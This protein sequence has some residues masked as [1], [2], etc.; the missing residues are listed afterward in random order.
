[1]VG[2]GWKPPSSCGD[3]AGAGGRV[4]LRDIRTVNKLGAGGELDLIDSSDALQ[5]FQRGE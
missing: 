2:K 1:M 4:G 5:M 3:G